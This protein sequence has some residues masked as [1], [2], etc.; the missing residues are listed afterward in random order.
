MEGVIGCAFGAFWKEAMSD[1]GDGVVCSHDICA[2]C[3]LL[4]RYGSSAVLFQGCLQ[5]SNLCT[6]FVDLPATLLSISNFLDINGFAH[7]FL[8]TLRYVAS[9]SH[10]SP[11][12]RHLEHDPLPSFGMSQRS[13]RSRV[14]KAHVTPVHT[15]LY[16]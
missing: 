15:Q 16:L 11:V 13:Y 1:R 5:V 12:S 7:A 10:F 9:T 3:R 14:S 8:L 6:Q 2:S 4:P